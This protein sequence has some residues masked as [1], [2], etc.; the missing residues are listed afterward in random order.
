MRLRL[1]RNGKRA[2]GK[3]AKLSEPVSQE[4]LVLAC[5]SK[6]GGTADSLRFYLEGG[7]EVDADALEKDDVVYVAF[8][9]EDYIEELPIAPP[10][11]AAAAES[12]FSARVHSTTTDNGGEL[13]KE[14]A[15]FISHAKAEAAMEAR[16]VQSWLEERLERKCFI[17]SDD[18]HD[19]TRLKAHVRNSSVLVIIQSKH[20]LTRP[21][22]LLELLTA[23]D[24]N[25]PIIGLC[26]TG[27]GV[28]AS[29]DYAEAQHFLTHLDTQ[30]AD[31]P[32]AVSLLAENGHDDLLEAAYLLSNSLP[33]RIS[34]PLEPGGSS[35]HINANL[36]RLRQL[37]VSAQPLDRSSLPSREAWLRGRSA[38]A[39]GNWRDALADHRT[40]AHYWPAI[41]GAYIGPN[42]L[43]PRLAEAVMLTINSVNL[44]SFC[45]G[46]HCDLGRL[47]GLQEPARLN[48][49]KS[50]D[51]ALALVAQPHHRAG[52]R[53]ARIF[54]V[55]DGRGQRDAD[56]YE[57]L[58][59]A[60]GP[61]QASAVRA[62]CWFLYWG[63]YV[64]NTLN[65]AVGY[66][67]PKPGTSSRF[68]GQLM[69]YYGMLFFGV[70]TVVSVLLK[71]VPVP[72]PVLVYRLLGGV[73]S[74]TAGA[75]FVPL[76]LLDM[77]LHG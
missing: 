6:L 37:L 40:F 62:L 44:C 1:R 15:A 32:S 65:A 42:A 20:V 7:D 63:S 4:G 12:C 35:E 56:A 69:A 39:W 57:E 51:A 50:V 53:Y 60:Y 75:F 72:V 41:L 21:F 34:V 31:I 33:N 23:I 46:L 17:D 67:T 70:I 76:G 52:V 47:S 27:V 64:G 36:E 38:K 66:K 28:R 29:Y 16:F 59:G 49:A 77:L 22:C 58:V 48:S 18:L 8:D 25:V 30:L 13:A 43:D 61:G 5:V 73:L 55:C 10:P 74:C 2:G 14:F 54:A 24:H 19:L 68:L 71:A 26:L 11:A 45:S 3:V 9:G